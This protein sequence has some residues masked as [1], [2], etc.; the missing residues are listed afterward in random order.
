MNHEVMDWPAERRREGVS[1]GSTAAPKRRPA[2]AKKKALDRRRHLPVRKKKKTK[3]RSRFAFGKIF[4]R[5]FVRSLVISVAV[6]IL[7]VLSLMAFLRVRNVSVVGNSMYS[8]TE[9]QQAAGINQGSALLLVNKTAV[10]SRIKAQLLYVDDVRVG[11]SLPDTVKIEVE[12]LESAYAI[13]AQDGSYWLINSEGRLIEQIT[14]KK[15]SEYLMIEGIRIQD[16]QAGESLQVWEAPPPADPEEEE[17]EQEEEEIEKPAEASAAERMEVALQIV[18]KLEGSEDVRSI[19]S[20]D[21]SSIYQIEIWYGTQYQ[22]K[23]GNQSEL[24]YKLDY[25][26]AAIAQL[27]SYQTGVLDLTFEEAKKAT[28]IPWTS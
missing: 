4:G 2:S 16:A 6:A 25:M 18:K 5:S 28:F 19:R 11:I 12:E 22:V 21:V 8:A 20:I 9:I 1:R 13:A 10:A 7:V 26:L 3:A 24:S 15:A 27:E 14:A 17:E 23:L